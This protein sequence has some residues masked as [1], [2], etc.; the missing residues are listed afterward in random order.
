MAICSLSL[1]KLQLDAVDL[2][3]LFLLLSV[4]F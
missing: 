4:I 3:N 2:Y 1:N